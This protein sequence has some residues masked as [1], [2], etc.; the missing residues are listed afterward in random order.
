MKISN[1]WQNYT[2]PGLVIHGLKDHLFVLNWMNACM[3]VC[4]LHWTPCTDM[5]LSTQ[6]WWQHFK[7]SETTAGVTVVEESVIVTWSVFQVKRSRL[8]NTFNKSQERKPIAK[9][10]LTCCVIPDPLDKQISNKFLE[11]IHSILNLALF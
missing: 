1:M 3:D 8:D 2:F 4:H 5:A 9:R 6:F 10:F 7:F 11:G